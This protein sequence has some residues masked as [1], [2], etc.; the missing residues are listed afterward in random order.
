[1][2]SDI[3]R[4]GQVYMD[5]KRFGPVYG[6]AGLDWTTEGLFCRANSKYTK[7]KLD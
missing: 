3:E 7:D 5:M 1:M 6:Q 2:P 4:F